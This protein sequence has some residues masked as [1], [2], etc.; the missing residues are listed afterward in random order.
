MSVVLCL[1]GQS[2]H[3]FLNRILLN[4]TLRYSAILLL[5]F[6]FHPLPAFFEGIESARNLLVATAELPTDDEWPRLAPREM[7]QA[8][9]AEQRMCDT[10]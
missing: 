3:M 2:T 8:L 9:M 5:F 4:L 7:K 1:G 6:V 10:A